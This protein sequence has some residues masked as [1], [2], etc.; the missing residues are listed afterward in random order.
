MS[1]SRGCE[2]GVAGPDK[3]ETTLSG[4]LPATAVVHG[5]WGDIIGRSRAQIVGSLVD[6]TILGSTQTVRI[7]QRI[8]PATELVDAGIAEVMTAGSIY[9]IPAAAA[10]VWRTVGGAVRFSAHAFGTA[11]D[12]NPAQNPY[13]GTN[14]LITN[15]PPWFRQIWNDAGFCWGGDWTGIK[16]PMHYSWSGPG[17]TPGY[18]G[19]P[20]PYPP[21]TG[22][23]PFDRVALTGATSLGAVSGSQYG[24]AD[25]SGDGSAD[26]Y[27]LQ[28]RGS[29][30]RLEV[31]G[32]ASGYRL[33]GLR[34]DLSFPPDRMALVADHDQDGRPDLWIVDDGGATI[35]LEVWTSSTGYEQKVTLTTGIDTATGDDYAMTLYDNDYRP[36]LVVIDSSGPTTATVYAAA[37]GY[38][39][40]LRTYQIAL[41]ATDDEA[42]WAILAGDWDVDGVTD[43]YAVRKGSAAT[44]TVTTDKGQ[45]TNLSTG[46]AIDPAA[47]ILIS[48]FDGDGR[49]DLYL[50]KGAALTVLLGG[51]SAIGSEL[52]D[53]Y[54]KEDGVPW[55]AGPECVGPGSCDSIGYVDAGG[56]WHLAD[57]PAFDTGEASFYF[58]NPGDVPFSGDWDCDGIDTP[59]L[60]RTRDGYVYLRGS[61][62]QGIADRSFFFGNPGDVP[63]V[64]DFDGDGC[65]TVN[66]YRP[67][68]GRFYIIDHLGDGDAGL[69]AAEYSFTFGDGGDVPFAGDFDGDGV[70]DIGLHRPATGLVYLRF[71]LSTGAADRTFIF[72]DPGDVVVAGDWNGDG[73]DT[74]AIFR[75]GDGNWYLRLTN[76]GGSADHAVH[77]HSHDAVTRPVVGTFAGD[78]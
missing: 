31:A 36:D 48:D 35:S 44:V 34:H 20:A 45:T 4:F 32:S 52:T 70:T 46:R 57:A 65:D 10:W 39:R 47:E 43:L 63:L 61:N 58:G 69:G 21:L 40:A 7:H 42:A 53:W 12:V 33:I 11:I 62:T 28:P 51:S 59:G 64:G 41:G 56:L 6:W 37:G 71:S 19:R 72:G 27:R 67:R 3:P 78:G 13:S 29:G 22:A 73:V 9:A 2:P 75:R 8:L 76:D 60:F 68:D 24:L 17:L 77:F 49:D 54:I 16:D 23:R 74:V 38:T 26:L 5:P 30:S 1:E 14:T 18:P 50:R 66:I 15:M 55:D 25:F